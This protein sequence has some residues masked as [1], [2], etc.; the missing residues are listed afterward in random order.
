MCVAS[1][2]GLFV[3]GG[4]VCSAG[5]MHVGVCESCAG[6]VLA[7]AVVSGGR[8]LCAAGKGWGRFHRSSYLLPLSCCQSVKA[9]LR[10]RTHD[11]R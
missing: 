9:S 8:V 5:F 2:T 4:F 10:G 3:L 11:R 7:A 1:C 6:E